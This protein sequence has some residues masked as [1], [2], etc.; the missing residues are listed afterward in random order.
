MLS[1]NHP[2]IASTQ[3]IE[4]QLPMPTLPQ[5]P[6]DP[7]NPLSWIMVLTLLLG[8]TEKPINASAKLICAIAAL[9]KIKRSK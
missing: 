3:T 7:T 2:A 4:P 1:L 6:I 8:T 5:I 9:I